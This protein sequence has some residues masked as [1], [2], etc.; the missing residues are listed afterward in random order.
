[1]TIRLVVFGMQKLVQL[2]TLTKLEHQSQRP[3][4]DTTREHGRLEKSAFG[5][6][7]DY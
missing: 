4:I 6:L 3:V 7:P 5:N 1:M 2:S